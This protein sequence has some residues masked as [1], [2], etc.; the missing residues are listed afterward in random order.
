MDAPTN[1]PESLAT[2]R[3]SS[4]LRRTIARLLA[5]ASAIAIAACGSDSAPPPPPPSEGQ[6]TIGAAGGTVQGPDGVTLVVPAGALAA[7]TTIRIARSSSGAPALP[8]ELQGGVPVYEITPHGLRFDQAVT[9][10]LPITGTP[11]D[12]AAVLV[13]EPGGGW[14]SAAPTVAAGYLAIQRSSLSW[15]THTSPWSTYTGCA[16][17]AGDPY[18]CT[19]PTLRPEG[20]ITVT[21]PEA[22]PAPRGL[23]PEVVQ[24]TS[25]TWPVRITAPRDCAAPALTVLRRVVPPG[26]PVT[27]NIPYQEVDQRSIGLTLMP[28][29]VKRSTA[30]TTYTAQV[31]AGDNHSVGLRFV[32]SCTRALN[33]I[34]YNTVL[35]AGY[36]AQVPAA[37]GLPTITQQPASV[38]IVD[39]N[40][41]EFRVVA[42]APDTLAI[43]WQRSNDGGTTW[44]TVQASGDAYALAPAR[45]A[46]TG[47]RFRAQVC[48][49][50]GTALNCI[51]SDVATLT[52]VPATVAPAFTQQPQS[53]SVVEGQSASFTVVATATPTPTVRWY[54]EATSGPAAQVGPTCT[55]SAGQTTCTY[56]T[57][58]LSLADNGARFFAIATNGTDNLMSALATLTVT[59][60][61]VAPSIPAAEPADVSVTVGQSATFSVNATGTAP[62]SYQWQRNGANI[63]GANGASYTLANAQIVDSGARF[64]VVVSNGV[65]PATSRAALLTVTAP[66]QPSAGICT[67]SNPAGWCWVQPAPHSNELTALAI[68]GRTIHAVGRRTSMRSSDD[69]A[70]WQIDFNGIDV[71]WSD[72]ASPAPGVLVAAATASYGGS[73]L[74]L[75]LHRSTDG[76]QAWTFVL[77]QPVNAVVFESATTGIAVGAGIWRTT[78]GGVNWSVVQALS[79]MQLDLVVSPAPGVYVAIG[80]MLNTPALIMRSVDGGLTWTSPAPGTSD[81]L[82]DIAFGT[83]TDGVIAT[84]GNVLRTTDGGASWSA[85]IAV[86]TSLIDTV[87]FANGS[88][89][90]AMGAFGEVFR[91]SDAGLTWSAGN[92]PLLSGAQNIARMKFLSATDG[93]AV[94]FYGQIWRTT[95]A[96]Q[97]WSLVAGGSSLETFDSIEF[98][99]GEGMAAAGGGVFRTLDGGATWENMGG[100]IAFDVALLDATVRVAVG[101]GIRRTTDRGQTWSTV[102]S[103]AVGQTLR[104]VDFVPS[105][106]TTGV[107]VGSNGSSGFMLRTTDGGQTWSSVFVGAVPALATVAFSASTP[108]LGIAAGGDRTLLRTTDGGATWT[109]LVASALSPGEFIQAV[110]V[111]STSALM[112]TD[113]GL[114][115]ST[116]GG[117]G[118]TRVYTSTLGSMLD[119]AFIGATEAVAVGVAGELARSTDAGATWTRVDVPLTV[120]LNGVAYTGNGREVVVV[121]DGGT[122]LRNTQGGAP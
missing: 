45:L 24:P 72:V 44:T 96:G 41:A 38:S 86:T 12:E 66:P 115:R 74:D 111:G 89:V 14:D 60:A 102:H 31:A 43:S 113:D 48:N 73:G 19:F 78:D 6:A 68:N 15:Y 104:A 97:N 61:A 79:I 42:T 62:L 90:V 116:D 3:V 27:A 5:T 84:N 25:I 50:L 4:R 51:F 54:R 26:T 20:D 59:P 98:R 87:A 37:P 9:I 91:S 69:G 112:A 93:Y 18:S 88:T 105:T 55:G 30:T 40:R 85:P 35:D 122:I 100:G 22:W 56:T 34:R 110:R 92:T 13:A 8:A 101:A 2:Q 16:P 53:T 58:S 23:W 33:G 76:G 119:V 57:A 64:S 49:A 10:R 47:A 103:T 95:D 1:G 21:P 121:G 39:G 28:S 109:V 52:V 81:H 7:D 80:S 29:D 75:G 82:A 36:R 70:T 32:F 107:A 17:R 67:S 46:D 65:G 120:G 118:W 117:L 63:A 106:G 77:P 114:Y 11:G 94:G 83:A 99:G 71:Y 108:N